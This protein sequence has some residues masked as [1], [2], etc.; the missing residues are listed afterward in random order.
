VQIAI[1][2]KPCKYFIDGGLILKDYDLRVIEEKVREFYKDIEYGG[3]LKS[4]LHLLIKQKDEVENDIENS[5][6]SLT[7]DIQAVKYDFIKLG[8]ISKQSQQDKLI[9]QAFKN[10]EAQLYKINYE[11]IRIKILIRDLENKTNDIKFI[12][13]NLNEEYI[14]FLEMRYKNKK[15]FNDIGYTLNMS[16]TSARRL[17]IE[18]LSEISLCS[19]LDLVII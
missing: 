16:E 10:L 12:I 9:E 7:V 8:T 11:I 19:C 17:R 18:I 6:I 4:K 3:R 5:N 15:A 2:L 13:E 14:K 1:I